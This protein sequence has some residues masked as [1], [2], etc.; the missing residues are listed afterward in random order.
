VDAV[1][2]HKQQARYRQSL[3]GSQQAYLIAI[4]CSA[5]PDGRDQWTLCLLADK[6]VELGFVEKLSPE[7]IRALLNKTSRSHGGI[8]SGVFPR[9]VA[10]SWRLWQTCWRSMPASPSRHTSWSRLNSSPIGVIPSFRPPLVLQ[11]L[12]RPCSAQARVDWS[13]PRAMLRRAKYP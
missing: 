2:Q 3:T 7:T 12:A 8:A 1:L 11:R 5:V 6:A 13:G 10:S 9:S 4:A